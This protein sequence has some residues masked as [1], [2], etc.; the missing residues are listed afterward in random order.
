M[1]SFKKFLGLNEIVKKVKTP[2]GETKWA[3]VSR[4]DPSKVLQ[5]YDGDG[6]PSKGWV[7]KA[8]RRVQYFKS[9]G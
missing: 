2:E 3:L 6:K 8:E 4:N 7:S 9:K 5:Y 1:L